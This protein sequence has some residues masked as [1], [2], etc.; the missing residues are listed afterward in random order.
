L[1]FAIASLA[2]GLRTRPGAR[3]GH[4]IANQLASV[5]DV[6]DYQNRYMRFLG[7]W[8][9][10]DPPES[11]IVELVDHHGWRDRVEPGGQ[12]IGSRPTVV[13]STATIA[14]S[15]QREIGAQTSGDRA[16]PRQLATSR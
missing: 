14:T 13:S 4:H 5:L 8:A 6:V 3:A 15:D 10:G 11:R 16:R 1:A 12:Q 7:G 9:S 2:V